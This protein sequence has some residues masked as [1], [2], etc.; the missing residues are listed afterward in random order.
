MAARTAG[1]GN[2][3][4]IRVVDGKCD[5]SSNS[6][7]GDGA[8]GNADGYDRFSCCDWLVLANVATEEHKQYLSF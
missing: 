5:D 8:A 3:F 1:A 7:P 4:A 2:S 6:T